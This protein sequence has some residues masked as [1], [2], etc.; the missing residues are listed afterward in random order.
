MYL[1]SFWTSAGDVLTSQLHAAAALLSGNNPGTHREGSF[2]GPTVGLDFWKCGKYLTPY[3][4]LNPWLIHPVAWSQNWLWYPGSRIKTSFYW[5][6]TLFIG[7][8]TSPA[9]FGVVQEVWRWLVPSPKR[10][11]LYT[12]AQGVIGNT[13]IFTNITVRFSNHK[14]RNYLCW[15]HTVFETFIFF[16]PTWWT[17]AKLRTAKSMVIK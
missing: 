9:L 5:D 16:L 10:W 2:V 3:Q 4:D 15:L 14:I 11:G 7:I 13:G 6:T 8:R 17:S 1:Q 12:S